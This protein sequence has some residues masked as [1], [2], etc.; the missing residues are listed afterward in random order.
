MA[1]YKTQQISM[2]EVFALSLLEW[3]FQIEDALLCS[4]QDTL[5]DHSGFER[6][7][8]IKVDAAHAVG[9]TWQPKNC[10]DYTTLTL[11]K[12]K[13]DEL[14]IDK[15]SEIHGDAQERYLACLFLKIMAKTIAS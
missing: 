11:Q 12:K 9:I 13:F 15:Q 6:L 14:D 7:S 8:T 4:S 1:I 5:T 3:I 2:K 10:L